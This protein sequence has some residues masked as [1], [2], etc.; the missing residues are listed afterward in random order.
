MIYLNV[1]TIVYNNRL[2]VSR[3]QS[4]RIVRE[5]RVKK[6]EVF[7]VSA[8]ARC[9]HDFFVQKRRLRARTLRLQIALPYRPPR[10]T[11]TLHYLRTTV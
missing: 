5:A 6:V 11:T 10:L 4:V 7:G 2:T 1:R 8:R 9:S 3:S